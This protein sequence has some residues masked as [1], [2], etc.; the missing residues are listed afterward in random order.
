M[1]ALARLP[2]SPGEERRAATTSAGSPGVEQKLAGCGIAP[3]FDHEMLKLFVSAERIRVRPLQQAKQLGQ[4]ASC[5]LVRVDEEVTDRQQRRHVE[6]MVDVRTPDLVLAAAIEVREELARG[7]RVRID[8][9]ELEVTLDR[10]RLHLAIPAFEVLPPQPPLE[11]GRTRLE[12]PLDLRIGSRE[13]VPHV[14][15]GMANRVLR[16][17]HRAGAEVREPVHE[18]RFQVLEQ[19]PVTAQA[20]AEPALERV[21]EELG[22]EPRHRPRPVGRVEEPRSRPGRGEGLLS[23]DGHRH[24]PP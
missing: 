14:L 23:D 19:R 10:R 20:L 16:R 17:S 11:D 8:G 1:Y 22:L 9:E 7:E 15:R 5:P 2:V 4:R 24:R 3:E 6:Q 12:P 18:S 21:R 13:P